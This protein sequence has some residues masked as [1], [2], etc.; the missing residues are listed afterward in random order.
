MYNGG[1]TFWIWR[2][3]T[4]HRYWVENEL[5][6]NLQVDWDHYYWGEFEACPITKFQKGHAQ[7]ICLESVGRLSRTRRGD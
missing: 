6:D 3:D 2:P 5:P 1:H 4:N 7:G